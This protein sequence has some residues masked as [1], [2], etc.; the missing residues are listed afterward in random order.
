ME[1][2]LT[3]LGFRMSEDEI[4]EN[5]VLKKLSVLFLKIFM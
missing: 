4:V 3:N 2:N 5:S 1:K